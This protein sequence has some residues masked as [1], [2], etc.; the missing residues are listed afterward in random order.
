M[1]REYALKVVAVDPCHCAARSS[2]CASSA[3]GIMAVRQACRGGIE[4]KL[5]S[6]REPH[7]VT[8][9]TNTLFQ[10][11]LEVFDDSHVVV[12]AMRVQTYW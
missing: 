9:C 4:F 12:A 11:L 6:M 3:L 8:L 10:R 7:L 5:D 2:R 1:P